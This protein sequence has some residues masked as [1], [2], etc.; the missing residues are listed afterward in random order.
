MDNNDRVSQMVNVQKEGLELF[1]KK[2]QDYGDAFANYGVIGV[3]VRMG[4]KISRLQSITNKQ[5]SLINTESIRDTLIDLHN[6]SA[7]AIML[8][9]ESNQTKENIHSCLIEPKL[10]SDNK[11]DYNTL[12]DEKKIVTETLNKCIQKNSQFNE[13]RDLAPMLS[14][15]IINNNDLQFPIDP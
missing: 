13:D 7:M 14:R 8:L 1:K 15:P 4:D 10:L 6:Y 2:N 11:F 12:L 9:D 5:V 3:L